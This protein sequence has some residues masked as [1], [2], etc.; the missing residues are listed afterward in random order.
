MIFI[1]FSLEMNMVILFPSSAFV[2]L[3]RILLNLVQVEAK[4]LLIIYIIERP[5]K[6]TYAFSLAPS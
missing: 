5:L 4:F 2:Q 1:S 3:F 6:K